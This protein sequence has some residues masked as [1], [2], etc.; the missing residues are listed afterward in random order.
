MNI[1]KELEKQKTA[2][3]TEMQADANIKA[4]LLLEEGDSSEDIRL[5]KALGSNNSIMR[6]LESKG[7]MIELEDLRNKYKGD[8]F[9]RDQIKEVARKFNL[10]FL[11]TKY[12][13][14]NIPVETLSKLKA[15]G[16]ET[17]TSLSEGNMMYNFYILAPEKCFKLD[18]VKKMKVDPDPA[19]F[20]KIDDNTYRM[21]HQWGQD[22]TIANRISGWIW[23]SRF[24][25]WLVAMI[26]T[27]APVATIIH[28]LPIHA[29][30]YLIALVVGIIVS[31]FILND[32]ITDDHEFH[33]EK[34]NS[35]HKMV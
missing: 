29:A 6:G 30:F 26:L 15:F 28:Y 31:I 32:E 4:V 22:F 17:N 20:F 13:C 27:V 9:T 23:Q 7:R 34:W 1:T 35:S 25:L 12:Y 2:D 11:T 5:A 19:L 18:E 24:N 3:Q 14:G 33:E 21:I 10:R 16:K 8:I